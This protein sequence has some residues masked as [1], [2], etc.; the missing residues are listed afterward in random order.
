MRTNDLVKTYLADV[1]AY[2]W[3]GEV[4][5]PVHGVG[6]A[7]GYKREGKSLID[8]MKREVFADLVD[9]GSVRCL[10]SGDFRDFNAHA[11][12][13]YPFS[14]WGRKARP[15]SG[16]RHEESLPLA[17]DFKSSA[18]PSVSANPPMEALSALDLK[19]SA[20]FSPKV[21]HLWVTD[22]P[23]VTIIVYR[24][25]KLGKGRTAGPLTLERLKADFGIARSESLAEGRELALRQSVDAFRVKLTDVETALLAVSGRC[26]DLVKLN[27]ALVEQGREHAK[28]LDILGEKLH[29]IR[30][31]QG[32]QNRLLWF[33]PYVVE[34]L[35]KLVRR[36]FPGFKKSDALPDLGVM[37]SPSGMAERLFDDDGASPTGLQVGE[38]LRVVALREYG[39]ASYFKNPENLLCGVVS[40]GMPDERWEYV[41]SV[42]DLVNVEA[43]AHGF[44]VLQ[45]HRSRTFTTSANVGAEIFL[46]H[47]AGRSRR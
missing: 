40:A 38:W 27:A 13:V 35:E 39:D 37:C 45:K 25:R 43:E 32:E 16:D 23:G 12:V 14:D 10:R 47:I 29:V 31:R 8:Q 1:P 4:W 5:W 33:L 9:A 15:E 46:D 42:V 2:R 3:R 44:Y 28:A 34:M 20:K 17:L 22:A 26:S 24:T 21:R 19:S 11:E 7:L 41:Q 36:F 18:N 30:N 6:A